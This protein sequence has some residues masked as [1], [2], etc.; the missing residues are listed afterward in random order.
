MQVALKCHAR[1]GQPFHIPAAKLRLIRSPTLVFLGEND[2]LIG[3][4]TAAA[5]RARNIPDCEIEI[6]SRAGH[7]MNIDE[8]EFVGTRSVRFLAA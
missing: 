3:S 4:A 6:L 2:G 7:I 1:T 8:P 5:R